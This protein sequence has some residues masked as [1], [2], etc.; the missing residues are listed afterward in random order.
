MALAE[1]LDVEVWRQFDG[2]DLTLQHLTGKCIAPKAH[3]HDQWS[4]RLEAR[5][6]T[7]AVPTGSVERTPWEEHL[8]G[9]TSPL[10]DLPE[11]V[12]IAPE[13]RYDMISGRE[14]LMNVLGAGW[15]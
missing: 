1:T 9:E 10:P 7:L 14:F 4:V 15:N 3:P 8:Y 13:L 5:T 12:V 6:R 11:T 2:S